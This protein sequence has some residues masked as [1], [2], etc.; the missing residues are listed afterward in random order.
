MIDVK[1]TTDEATQTPTDGAAAQSAQAS[2]LLILQPIPEPR[3][4][5]QYQLD[6][7]LAY[8]DRAFVAYVYNAICDH[9]PTAEEFAATLA[10]LRYGRRSKVEIIEG[11]CAGRGRARVLGLPSPLARRVARWPVVGRVLRLLRAL[12]RVPL[13]IEHQ[14]KFEAYAL[15]QQ[16]LIAD[17][18]NQ[19]LTDAGDA[20]AMLSE[21]LAEV[22]R[23]LAGH[24][25]FLV[26]EQR[27]I[28][29]TQKVVLNDLQAQLRESDARHEQARAALAAELAH[30]RALV[31]QLR[32][33]T[34]EGEATG[35]AAT[36]PEGE[37]T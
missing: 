37:Q 18:L 15:A 25:G 34:A 2:P 11:L 16:Q 30:L 10:D 24:E 6:E 3:A 36:P 20:L 27:V 14:Q 9:A 4:D 28:V 22:R 13:L 21:A 5:A 35:R 19:A 17:H 33:P 12:A 1:Q 23:E 7:L 8:H 26:Q 31:A 29:E 32:T